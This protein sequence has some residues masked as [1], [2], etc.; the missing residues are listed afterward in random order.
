MRIN[1]RVESGV[2]DN[3]ALARNLNQRSLKLIFITKPLYISS[4]LQCTSTKSLS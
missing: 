4:F 1:N 2:D 3:I